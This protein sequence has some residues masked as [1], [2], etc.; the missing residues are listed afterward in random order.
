MG[1]WP[2]QL[3]T[4][5]LKTKTLSLDYSSRETSNRIWIMTI[6]VIPSVALVRLNCNLTRILSIDLKTKHETPLLTTSLA[7]IGYIKR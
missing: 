7:K 2:R 3:S 4:E 5:V 6:E 1:I